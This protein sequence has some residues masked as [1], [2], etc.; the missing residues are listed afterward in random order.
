ME[1]KSPTEAA[2]FASQCAAEFCE[3]QVLPLPAFPESRIPIPRKYEQRKIYLAAPFFTSSKRWLVNELRKSLISFGNKV[4]SPY[5]DV[6]ILNDVTFLVAQ[7]D[8]AQKNLA[9]LDEADVILTVLN[10]LDAGTIMELGYAVAKGKR[11]VV[12]VENINQNN[13][14]MIA[15]SGCEVVTDISTAIYKVSW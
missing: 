5:H 3:T 14:T 12:L 1:G 2:V 10:G 15:G 11:V 7:T 6:G 13:L 9:A 4:F 8:I